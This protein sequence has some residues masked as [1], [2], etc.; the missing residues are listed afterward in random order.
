METLSTYMSEP[1]HR[2]LSEEP[3][4]HARYHLP[5]SPYSSMP[6]VPR[7]LVRAHAA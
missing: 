3:P 2:A 1:E 7:V 6:A 4:E 5:E